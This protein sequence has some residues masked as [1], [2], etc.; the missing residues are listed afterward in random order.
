[1]GWLF[2]RKEKVFVRRITLMSK[3]KMLLPKLEMM[4]KKM[5]VY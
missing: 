5:M 3:R 1:L 2:E 4:T